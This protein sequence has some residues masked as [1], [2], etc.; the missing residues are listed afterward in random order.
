MYSDPVYS[1]SARDVCILCILCIQIPGVYAALFDA[2]GRDWSRKG[3]R[4]GEM[5]LSE[6]LTRV[7][8]CVNVNLTLLV[9]PHSHNLVLSTT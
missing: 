4:T 9:S 8:A 6:N 1:Q 3:V 2:I 5:C 7:C